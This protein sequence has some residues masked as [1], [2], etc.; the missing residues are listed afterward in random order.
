MFGRVEYRHLHSQT[1][2]TQYGR[3]STPEADRPTVSAEAFE[4]DADPEG[5]SLL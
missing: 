5:F 4:R 2:G 3:G 1:A